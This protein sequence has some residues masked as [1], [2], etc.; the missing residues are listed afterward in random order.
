MFTQTYRPGWHPPKVGGNV[1][2][3]PMLRLP[4]GCMLRFSK[5]SAILQKV[6]RR[7]VAAT[8]RSE[9]DGI[10]ANVAGGYYV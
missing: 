9:A 2:T 5:N 6:S 8:E 10:L 4:S 3:R 1:K 7:R